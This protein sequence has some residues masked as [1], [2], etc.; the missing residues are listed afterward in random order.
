MVRRPPRSTLTDTLFPYTTLFRSDPRAGHARAAAWHRT[1]A[2]GRLPRAVLQ[3][4]RRPAGRQLP[5]AAA[6]P[7]RR[8]LAG[9]GARVLPRPRQPH[10]AVHRAGARIPALPRS[11]KRGPGDAV[12]ARTGT[13][14]MGRT[15]I[16]R[17]HV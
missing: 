4:R 14:R 5:G 1:A 6:Y 12:A 3:Q 9:A 8:A 10:A 7:R 13:L 15:Q 11:A 16:G 2:P 17:A